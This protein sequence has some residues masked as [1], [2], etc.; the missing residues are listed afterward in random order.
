MQEAE[1]VTSRE[2]RISGTLQLL[3]KMLSL[4]QPPRRMES[5]DISNIAGT[6]IVASMVVFLDG[7]PYK[8]DYKRFKV[9]GL[10]DQDD[11]ASMAQVVHR[12]FVHYQQGDAGFAQA[13]DLLLID[14]GITHAETARR[15]LEA[16]GLDFP[17]FGMVKDGKHRTRALVTPE[18]REI[19]LDGT[20]AVFALIG[21]IQE[22]THR[23]AITYHREL[24]SKRLRYSQLD[25]IPGVGPKRKELLLRRFK[26]LTAIGQ[27]TLEEL[28]A[29]L[30]ADAAAAIYRHFHKEE[31]P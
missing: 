20:P 30:P 26:S 29:L 3:G 2:E 24:R 13:P 21:T 15:A 28:K 27:A 16:L 8:K 19:A 9:E 22:E 11:Y 31:T 5:F 23:F 14:G 7:R 6:D 12:R 10:E 17:V 1:R 25:E 4:P 18:G